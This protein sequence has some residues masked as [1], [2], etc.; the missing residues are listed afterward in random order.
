MDM[1]KSVVESSNSVT[2]E[3][4]LELVEVM[5]SIDGSMDTPASSVNDMGGFKGVV[6]GCLDGFTVGARDGVS[7][8]TDVGSADGSTEGSTVGNTVGKAVKTVVGRPEGDNV[9]CLVGNGD[10]N[11]TVGNCDAEAVIGGLEGGLVGTPY[12]TFVGGLVV[13]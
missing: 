7:V 2:L 6:I 11:C 1:V 9:G 5:D 10:C 13:G 4:V 12:G 3:E 8:R